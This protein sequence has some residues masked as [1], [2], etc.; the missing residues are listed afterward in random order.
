MLVAD[1]NTPRATEPVGKS[2]SFQAAIDKDHRH[3]FLFNVLE[4][5]CVRF[6]FTISSANI[7]LTVFAGELTESKLLVGLV[8]AMFML[9]W[10]LP[11]IVSAH[12]TEHLPR[13]RGLLIVGR[14]GKA[15]PWLFLGTWLLTIGAENKTLT[16][17]VF[18]VLLTVFCVWGGFMVPPWVSFLT[19]LIRR[20]HLGRLYG[21]RAF[22]GYSM[23]LAASYL[24]KRILEV[25]EFPKGYAFIF[26]LT[27]TGFIVATFFLRQTREPADESANAGATQGLRAFLRQAVEMVKQHRSFRVFLLVVILSAFGAAGPGAGIASGFYSVYGRKVL[28]APPGDLGMY[29]AIMASCQLV[30]VLFGGWVI[31]RFGAKPVYGAALFFGIGAALTSFFAPNAGVFRLTFV[32]VGLAMG[33]FAISYHNMII[34]LAPAGLRSTYMGI[35]NTLRG[36]FYAIAPLLGGA[37]VDLTSSFRLLFAL[38]AFGSVISLAVLLIFVR[39]PRPAEG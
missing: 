18:F 21:L 16:L 38:A 7:L 1:Q 37:I 29:I 35:S 39:V 15:V 25:Y 28:N 12:K 36:P 32:F 13:K 27:G 26:L 33:F 4:G 31:D 19:K 22:V 5:A 2:A 8:P 9:F 17:I 6:A 23:A 11:Q 10:T 30:A 20:T 34:A 14:L 24:V 3:N